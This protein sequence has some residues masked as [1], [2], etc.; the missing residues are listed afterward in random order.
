LGY[1]ERLLGSLSLWNTSKTI[2]NVW[3]VQRLMRDTFGMGDDLM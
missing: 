3:E 1:Y 2:D